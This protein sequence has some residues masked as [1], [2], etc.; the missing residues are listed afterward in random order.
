M[1]ISGLPTNYTNQSQQ[2]TP[3]TKL[4]AN[5]TTTKTQ[6]SSD[7]YQSLNGQNA[8]MRYSSSLASFYASNAI[9]NSYISNGDY[10]VRIHNRPDI[11]TDLYRIAQLYQSSGALALKHYTAVNITT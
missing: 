1:N 7:S 10:F 5:T 9:S 3:S 6:P 4:N 8:T 2:N 11:A